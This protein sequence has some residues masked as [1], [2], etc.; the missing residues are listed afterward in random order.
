MHSAMRRFLL[1]SPL[2][3][4]DVTNELPNVISTQSTRDAG[5]AS[6]LELDLHI[7]EKIPMTCSRA[8]ATE[9]VRDYY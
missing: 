3:L 5:K 7:G 1:L 9:R 2:F 8:D 6:L 4:R